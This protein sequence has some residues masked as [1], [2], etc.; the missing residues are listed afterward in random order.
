[1]RSFSSLWYWIALAGMWVGISQRVLGI[2]F[3]MVLR[4]RKYGAEMQADLE[5]AVRIN[6][7]RLFHLRAVAG[8]WGL[9]AVSFTLTALGLLGFW[10]G[11]ELAQAL[12][13][14]SFPLAVTAV[15]EH[16]TAEDIRAQGHKGEALCQRLARHRLGAQFLGLNTILAAVLWGMWQNLNTSVL[17]G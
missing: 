4:A 8:L 9:A 10:Y 16:A 14:L 13:F 12:F 7:N 5:D 3:G 11:V 1:M 15:M 2:P 17:G 6:I